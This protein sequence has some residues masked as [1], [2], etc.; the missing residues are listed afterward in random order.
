MKCEARD[1]YVH[2]YMLPSCEANYGAN[3]MKCEYFLSCII[4]YCCTRRI[5]HGMTVFLS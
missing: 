3:M 1:Q 2:Y 5:N 4:F